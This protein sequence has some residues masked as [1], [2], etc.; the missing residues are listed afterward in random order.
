MNEAMIAILRAPED[1]APRHQ[2]E[3]DAWRRELVRL[4]CQIANEEEENP[5]RR[6]PSHLDHAVQLLFARSLFGG[7]F[8]RLSPQAVLS[9]RRGMIE[10][11]TTDL[12]TVL[13]H[14]TESLFT[15]GLA[16]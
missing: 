12:D 5:F 6:G 13:D 10:S 7:G 4:Q 14:C 15:A 8:L 3:V 1:G 11:L 2:F 9:F 16:Q